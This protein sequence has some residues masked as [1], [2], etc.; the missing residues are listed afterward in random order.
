MRSQ[1]RLMDEPRASCHIQTLKR[2]SAAVISSA[3]RY[4]TWKI[5]SIWSV[6]WML[7]MPHLVFGAVVFCRNDLCPFP[8]ETYISITHT[9]LMSVFLGKSG[10]SG[11]FLDSFTPPVTREPAGII[12]QVFTAQMLFPSHTQQCQS[13]DTHLMAFFPGQAG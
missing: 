8:P 5:N 2:S 7:V 11:C 9:V 4:S 10:L 12:T 1:P 6:W 3:Q 13:S